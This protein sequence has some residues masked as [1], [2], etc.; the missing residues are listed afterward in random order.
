MKKLINNK[1]PFAIVFSSIIA[2]FAFFLISQSISKPQAQSLAP[3]TVGSSI[4]DKTATTEVKNAAS[5]APLTKPVFAAAAGQNLNLKNSISW[6]FG[7]K[8][9]KGWYLY[10][11]LI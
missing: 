1:A 3:Q 5:H 6:A 9:Q 10:E 7:G 8:S 11:L 2:A 4:S